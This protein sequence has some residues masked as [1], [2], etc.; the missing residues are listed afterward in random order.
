MTFLFLC[1]GLFWDGT[2][3]DAEARHH[4]SEFMEEEADCCCTAT[5]W[6]LIKEPNQFEFSPCRGKEVFVIV[7]H[8]VLFSHFAYCEKRHE[9]C[10]WARS[11][12]P[13]KELL[14]WRFF[15]DCQK[16]TC[17]TNLVWFFSQQSIRWCSGL[18]QICW[19]WMSRRAVIKVNSSSEAVQQCKPIWPW[20]MTMFVGMTSFAPSTGYDKIVCVCVYQSTMSIGSNAAPPVCVHQW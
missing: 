18:G 17:E 8:R 11:Q 10:T 19:V 15:W 1:F 3:D 7:H 2:F 4:I 6:K 5:G 20:H 13:F 12:R 9:M 16:K 14:P